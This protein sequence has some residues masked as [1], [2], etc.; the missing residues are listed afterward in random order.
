[1]GVEGLYLLLA[2]G[3]GYL[4]YTA[5]ADKHILGSGCNTSTHTHTHTHTPRKPSP[6]S[7]ELVLHGFS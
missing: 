4:V 6:P 2:G 1:M 5:K 3:E 7:A